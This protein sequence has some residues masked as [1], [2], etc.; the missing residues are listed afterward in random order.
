MKM[1]LT[2]ISS[3]FICSLSFTVDYD[4]TIGIP[5]EISDCQKGDI[6]YFGVMSSVYKNLTITFT[7]SNIYSNPFTYIEANP[8]RDKDD[9]ITIS[10]KKLTISTKNTNTDLIMSAS[11]SVVY[12]EYTKFKIEFTSDIKDLTVKIEEEGGAYELS[13]DESKKLNYLLSDTAYYFY[14]MACEG[15]K[16]NFNLTMD[17]ISS[18]PIKNIFIY[19]YEYWGKN[20]IKNTSQPISTIKKGNQLLISFSYDVS[21]SY[22][23]FVAVAIEPAH[24]INNVEVKM[25][26]LVEFY[27][28]EN[29]KS[30]TVN[31]LV[32]EK[33]YFFF[34]NTIM[35]SEAQL[36]IN[37]NNVNVNPFNDTDIFYYRN[38]NYLFNN[39]MSNDKYKY[40]TIIKNNK[41][42]ISFHY[43]IS[44]HEYEK[45]GFK[46]QP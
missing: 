39:F 35:Y 43:S 28:L 8:L 20:V 19:E 46:F 12:L 38:R 15:L 24:D 31:K 40:N 33:I 30:I 32:P 10:G 36:S 3:L 5:L 6:Y 25:D 45:I 2:L 21:V 16:V 4:L 41:L 26:S 7:M 14:S 29:R 44:Y 17:Y 22:A 27:N 9:Y 13:N 18:N 34:I 1:I 11:Y 42:E 37:I 23:K